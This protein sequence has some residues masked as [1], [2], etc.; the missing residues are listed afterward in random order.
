MQKGVKMSK[1]TE[2]MALMLSASM[3]L[4]LLTSCNNGTGSSDMILADDPWYDLTKIQIGDVFDEQ[5]Y[6]YVQS[7]YVGMYGDKY[8]YHVAGLYQFP[9]GTDIND[10]ETL[11]NEYMF[12]D[13]NLYNADG[14][15]DGT[16][17]VANNPDIS[18][19]GSLVYINSIIDI[20]GTFFA[21]IDS[22]DE[23][24]LETTS[25][26]A[27]FDLDSL[28]IEDIEAVDDS[29]SERMAAED[30][31]DE[32]YVII[33]EYMINK[34]WFYNDDNPSYVLKVEDMEGQINEFNMMDMFPDKKIYDIANIVDIGNDRA[35]ICGSYNADNLYFVLDLSS[36]S[37]TDVSDDMGWL[38]CD[39]YNISQVDG[40]GA[41]VMDDLGLSAVD[42][43]NQTLTELFCFS[44]SNVNLNDISMFTPVSVTEDEAVFTGSINPNG[45]LLSSST[46]TMIYDFTKAD[47]NP[48]AGKTILTLASID[49]YSYPL[50]QAVCDFNQTNEEYFIRYDNS[51]DIDKYTDNS[52]TE[53]DYELIQDQ[54]SSDVGN[55]LAIAL[56]EG[57]GPDIIINGATLGMLNNSEYLLDMRSF[58]NENLGSD[59]YFDNIFEAASTNGELYQI[60]LSFY[61]MGIATSEDNVDEGQTGFT[62]EQYQEFVDGPCNG[63]NPISGG[64]LNLFIMALNCMSDQMFEDGTVNYD[65]EAFRSLAEYTSE[66]INEDLIGDDGSNYSPEETVASVV[67]VSS[68]SRYFDDVSSK[69]RVL[70]GIPSYDGR[71]PIIYS[72]SSVGIS[73]NSDNPEACMDFVSM[74]LSESTQVYYGTSEDIPVNRAA[75]NTVGELYITYHNNQIESYL[76]YMSED[77]LRMYGIDLQMMD[78]SA[79]G[80]FASVIESLDG[81]FTNDGSVNA[82]I[83]EEMPAFFEGQKTL[84]QV[85]PVINDRVQTILD[86]RL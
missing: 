82:I 44:D 16:L 41:V 15:L 29:F 83:R 37:L 81:W 61:I 64:K 31:S 80:E 65:N 26:R 33:G 28:T 5:T 42:Y 36:M 17:K 72:T 11:Y 57:T 3:M 30:G 20:D 50:C 9:E 77:M 8:V 27:R 39:P 59:Q 52:Q 23:E 85:I 32:G 84:D 35:L 68:V 24:A 49:G 54:A 63:N 6:E 70:L 73:A 34:Y 58:I 19:L 21:L 51:Y 7:D 79:I 76:R 10:T 47:T 46:V 13:I 45:D 1:K 43:D 75:F 40:I 78:E 53:E 25:Y 66:Y 56:M 67:T 60:P 12:D 18:E 74:L 62:F 2:F 14:S 71:G 38:N 48:N 22:F 69:G 4:P 86:E 55:N